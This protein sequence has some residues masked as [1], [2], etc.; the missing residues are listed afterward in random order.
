MLILGMESGMID[1]II[2]VII[3]IVLAFNIRVFGKAL[4]L[5][6]CMHDTMHLM[7]EDVEVELIKEHIAETEEKNKEKLFEDM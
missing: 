1:L 5:I 3:L 2:D 7:V 4:E 6:D